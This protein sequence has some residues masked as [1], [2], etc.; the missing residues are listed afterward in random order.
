M[1]MCSVWT[2]FMDEDVDVVLQELPF[3]VINRPFTLLH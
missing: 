1:M 3:Q 2:S